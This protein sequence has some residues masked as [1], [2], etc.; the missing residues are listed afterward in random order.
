[1]KRNK[2][3]PRGAKPGPAVADR[4][5]DVPKSIRPPLLSRRQWRWLGLA[6][7]V[8][9]S[10]ALRL[11]WR[12]ADPGNEPFWTYGYFVTDEGYYTSGGRLAALNGHCLDRLYQSI[13]RSGLP[14]C[15]ASVVQE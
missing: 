6:A 12:N 1:M 11:P 2:K 7:M 5:V 13:E 10:L 9:V 3:D 4:P 8:A 15:H 14:V